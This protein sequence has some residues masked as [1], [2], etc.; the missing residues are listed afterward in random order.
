MRVWAS[1]GLV[2]V[3]LVGLCCMLVYSRNTIHTSVDYNISSVIVPPASS[4]NK[5]DLEANISFFGNMFWG[6]Y[7]HDWSQ[8]S[9]WKY[10][11]PFLGLNQLEKKQYEFWV[12]GLECPI[13]D[14]NPTSS[15]QESILKFNCREEYLP[16]VGRWIDAFTLANN[17]TDNYEEVNG[18]ASTQQKLQKYGIEY[19]GSFDNRK[20]DICKLIEVPFVD[21][22]VQIQFVPIAFCGYHWVFGIPTSEQLSEIRKYSQN[23]ITIVLPHGGAEYVG[24]PDELKTQ[25]YRQMIDLGADMV[26]GD[27]PH[28]VQPVELYKGKLIAYS[29]GNFMFDQQGTFASTRSM[30]IRSILHLHEGYSQGKRPKIDIQYSMRCTDNSDKIFKKASVYDCEKIVSAANWRFTVEY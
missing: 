3:L 9:V 7:I 16:Y 4:L 27:H 17:H 29:L 10:E 19:F 25:L 2:G 26:I 23:Y 28:T 24:K 6:R 11:Y 21:S 22:L 5:P 14:V 18:F 13:A 30:S 8:E 20:D 12:S 15:E 1:F